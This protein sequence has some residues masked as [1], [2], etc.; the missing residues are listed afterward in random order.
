[1]ASQ[2]IAMSE[3][4]TDKAGLASAQAQ[5]KRRF[6]MLVVFLVGMAAM[7]LIVLGSVLAGGDLR[8]S[9]SKASS[10]AVLK[11]QADA[12]DKAIV[13]KDKD[14]IAGN[15]AEDFRQIDHEGNLSNKAGFLNGILSPKL[16]ID[17]YPVDDLDVRIYGA[18]NDVAAVSGRTR[19]TGAYKGKEFTANY[20]YIDIYAKKQGQWRVV[21]VQISPLPL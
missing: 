12:W 4:D 2:G 14:A 16:R 20:R 18:R 8:I 6:L 11:K 17:P 10:I 5:P 7:A 1:M 21:S 13:R 19:M 15:M 3:L 9:D